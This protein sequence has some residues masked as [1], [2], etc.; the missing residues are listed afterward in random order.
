MFFALSLDAQT[1]LDH[2]LLA[3]HQPITQQRRELIA[4][5]QHHCKAQKVLGHFTPKWARELEHLADIM[6]QLSSD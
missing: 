5:G 3:L 1:Q 4:Q 2:T 6:K